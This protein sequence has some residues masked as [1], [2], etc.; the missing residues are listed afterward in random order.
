MGFSERIVDKH[1]VWKGKRVFGVAY[2]DIQP[3][4]AD[5]YATRDIV[6]R[7][8]ERHRASD[9]SLVVGVVSEAAIFFASRLAV[10]LRAKF[11]TLQVSCVIAHC[12][13]GLINS[14]YYTG[15]LLVTPK[16]I[17]PYR[18]KT[19]HERTPITILH[20]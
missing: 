1:K 11:A 15:I 9:I 7:L 5:P 2:R 3:L 8:A 19:E 16:L 18:W 10:S 20:Q 12:R 4:L 14:C 17:L 6:S 13:S